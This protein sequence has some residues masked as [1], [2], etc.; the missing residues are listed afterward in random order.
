MVSPVNCVRW[1]ST[2]EHTLSFGTC[3]IR[4]DAGRVVDAGSTAKADFSK[5]LFDFN[6]M[7]LSVVVFFSVFSSGA[8][9][10]C[11]V[12]FLCACS[13]VVP[14]VY[15][16]RDEREKREK[17][18]LSYWGLSGDAVVRLSPSQTGRTAAASSRPVLD[19]DRYTYFARY[20]DYL[21]I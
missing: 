2:I 13:G 21:S 18:F 7:L 20:F 10:V 8:T 12:V 6:M 15:P 16:R 1:W 19:I 11:L 9:L 4:P 3:D 17:R 5:R 14:G